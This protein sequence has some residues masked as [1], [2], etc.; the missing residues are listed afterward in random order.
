[1]RTSILAAALVELSG[2]TAGA[3]PVLESLGKESL[4]RSGRLVL[5]GSGFGADGGGE[6]RIGGLEAW[7]ATWT[8]TR[9]V[10]FVPEDCELGARD[11]VVVTGDGQSGALPVEVTER[12]ADGRV[13]WTFEADSGT[14][15]FRPA[16]APDG[17][18]Y[19]H[20]AF[21]FV[22]AIASDGGLRWITRVIAWPYVPPSAGPDGTVC[23]GSIL[24]N[25]A[26]TAGGEVAWEFK[27]PNS[28]GPQVAATI[29]PDG[30]LYGAFDAG[31]GAFSVTANGGFRWSNSGDPF[32]FEFGG[33]GREARFGPSQAGGPMDQF[34]VGMER[35]G[36]SRIYGFSLAGEQ[37]FAIDAGPIGEGSEP[38]IGSDGTIYTTDFIAAGPGWV[39]R[40]FEPSAGAPL[41]TFEGG[42]NS[43][44]THL[45]IGPDDALYYMRDLAHLECL[46]PATLERRW[47]T[48]E[49]DVLSRPT[50][51]PDGS[52]LVV[53]GSPDHGEL[54]FIKG[55]DAATGEEVW[56]IP[57]PGE[58]YPRP[59]TLGAD[60]ARFSADGL[61][62]YISMG[63][64]PPDEEDP[65]C[66]L[67]AIDP[68]L[69]VACWADCDGNGVLELFDFLCFVNLF[70]A[71][72]EGADCDGDGELGLFDF[73]CFVNGFSGGC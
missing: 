38:A 48:F 43:G 67:Y 71:G 53:H 24:S 47:H 61:T 52:V 60:R 54:G 46:D 30:N 32:M 40:A 33:T 15:G 56:V 73:L 23:V 7:H 20:D 57:L 41:W 29:G 11:V 9:I 34:Y 55:F 65:S 66:L 42:F 4:A 31:M 39:I 6:V 62:A 2:L 10:A 18:L 16:I 26:I 12:Q 17:T 3:Q 21:G 63:S 49:G 27:D 64:V 25:F 51:S 35:D 19:V 69:E 70:N 36:P 8:G 13:R 59:R 50:I 14:L 58:Y 68:R 28:L 45:E 22:Y 44:I 37:R 5:H 1:M 72:E